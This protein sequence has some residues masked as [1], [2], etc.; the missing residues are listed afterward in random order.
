LPI[1]S[2]FRFPCIAGV[3][4]GF[5]CRADRFDRVCPFQGIR[6]CGKERPL[7]QSVPRNH[8][9]ASFVSL[10]ATFYASRQ[11]AVSRSRRASPRGRP[12][13]GAA[14]RRRVSDIF[15]TDVCHVERVQKVPRRK[16]RRCKGSAALESRLAGRGEMLQRF[17]GENERAAGSPL[18]S[19]S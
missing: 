12:V 3:Q 19:G 7:V 18:C 2:F 6:D 5:P 11:K 17:G 9:V 16:F 1:C 13:P 10:A 4:P 14:A 15:F 8:A